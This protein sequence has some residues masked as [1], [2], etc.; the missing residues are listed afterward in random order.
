LNK[1]TFVAQ[2]AGRSRNGEDKVNGNGRDSDKDDDSD[3]G[4]K[5]FVCIFLFFMFAIAI[6]FFVVEYKKS[7]KP[8]VKLAKPK[9]KVIYVSRPQEKKSEDPK[10]WPLIQKT[11]ESINDS[12]D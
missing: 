10:S 6:Y 2:I 8:E 5:V 7:Q 9:Y 11:V 1:G 3:V 12:M 4:G